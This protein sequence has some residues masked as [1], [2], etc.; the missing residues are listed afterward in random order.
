MPIP[1]WIIDWIKKDRL[2]AG[3]YRI[4][5]KYL[6]HSKRI[7]FMEG[8]KNKNT[9]KWAWFK[10]VVISQKYGKY[11]VRYTDGIYEC[12]CPFFKHRK[13]CSHILG[14]AQLTDVWPLKESIFPSKE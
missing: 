1:N 11:W 4:S 9:G 6:R 12:S 5:R 8:E 14:V 3:K 2:V 10:Y 7:Q 13:I